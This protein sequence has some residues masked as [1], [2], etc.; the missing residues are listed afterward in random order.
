MLN[1]IYTHGID[2][3]LNHI[4][5]LNSGTKNIN[6]NNTIKNKKFEKKEGINIMFDATFK[7]NYYY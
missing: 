7:Y 5:L 3:E 6:F 1:S 2:N 4:N